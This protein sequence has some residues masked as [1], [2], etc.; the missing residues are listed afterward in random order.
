LLP[1]DVSDGESRR[2]IANDRAGEVFGRPQHPYTRA[3]LDSIP[4]GDFARR[5]EA[6][7]LA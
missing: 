5:R 1:N 7:L 6:R 3:L 2:L 4:G